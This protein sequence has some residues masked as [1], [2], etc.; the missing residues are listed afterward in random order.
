MQRSLP[1]SSQTFKSDKMK[2]LLGYLLLVSLLTPQII[3]QPFLG[4]QVVARISAA[5]LKECSGLAPSWRN[6]G[7]LWAHNDSGDGPWIYAL[8]EDGTYLGGYNLGVLNTDFEDIAVG[9]GPDSTLTYIYVADIGNNDFAK[10]SRDTTRVYR[11]PEPAAPQNG[12]KIDL[13]GVKVDVLTFT[14]PTSDDYIDSEALLV[15]PLQ[16]DITIIRKHGSMNTVYVTPRAT[17]YAP[18]DQFMQLMNVGEIPHRTIT[19]GD[20]SRTGEEILL[21]SYDTIYYWRRNDHYYLSDAILKDQSTKLPYAEERQGEAICFDFDATGYY[22]LSE[23][24]A[25]T[26][27]PFFFYPRVGPP[28]TLSPTPFPTLFPTQFP[29]PFPTTLPTTLQPN[30][31]APTVGPT[32]KPTTAPTITPTPS[33][34][35]IAPSASPSDSFRLELSRSR[36]NQT[37]N[38]TFLDDNNT[39]FVAID[40]ELSDFDFGSNNDETNVEV[41][42]KGNQTEES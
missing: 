7:V 26:T 14:Y 42:R 41:S 5:D 4:G 12:E 17:I 11:L 9:P 21:K 38:A 31:F 20:I 6:P 8:S 39:A 10:P 1:T 32:A 28:P 25:Q 30:T 2:M 35:L 13:S 27:V 22:T 19:A 23:R 29:T 24:N 36:T 34:T 16:G 18:G 3:A 33:P 37:S 40:F 15:D